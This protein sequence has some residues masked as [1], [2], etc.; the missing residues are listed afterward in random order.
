MKKLVLALVM[1]GDA[2]LA[3]VY[4]RY[5]V[6]LDVPGGFEMLPPPGNDDGRGFT[7]RAGGRLSVWGSWQIEPLA[8]ERA[9]RKSSYL[10]QGAEIT[11]EAGG[12]TWFVLSGYL[13]REVFYLRVEDGQTCGGEDAR[14]FFEVTY[15]VEFRSRYDDLPGRFGKSLGFGPC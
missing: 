13:G 6:T 14:A 1:L 5:G 3:G 8:D 11:Y 12:K 15:P 7:D 9:F 10:E 2:A 4:G